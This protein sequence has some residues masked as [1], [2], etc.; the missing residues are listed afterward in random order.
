MNDKL[1]QDNFQ[2]MMQVNYF[3]TFLLTYLLFPFMRASAPSRIINV[4]SLALILGYIDFDQWNDV[5][6]YSNFGYYSN[7]KLANVLFTVEM[8]KIIR[9]SGVNVYSLDPGLGKSEFFRNY[10]DGFWKMFLKCALQKFGR[11][12]HRVA[13]MP[14]YLAVSPKV[15]NDSGKH[16]RDC[17]EFYSTWFANDTALTRRLWAESKRLTKVTSEEDWEA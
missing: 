9:G 16:Y 12:L 6:K 4:S 13:L 3:G 8:E 7:A 15:E 5:G 14:V 17:S 1:T 10:E 11:P 2:L